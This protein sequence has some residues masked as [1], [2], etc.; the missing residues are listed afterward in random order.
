[1]FNFFLIVFVLFSSNLHANPFAARYAINQFIKPNIAHTKP[2]YFG[3]KQQKYKLRTL[4]SQYHI[5]NLG[6]KYRNSKHPITKVR[7]T[8]DGFPVFKAKYSYRLPGNLLT[9]NDNTQF[10]S[11]TRSLKTAIRR[12]PN[13]KKGYTK[14]Q[15]A[16]IE[17]E[18][19]EIDGLS[20]H[21]SHKQSV[22][23]ELVDRKIHS[24][25]AHTGGRALWGEGNR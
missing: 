2:R 19:A 9:A 23:L 1:L 6:W 16:Q 25:T 14:K 15:L 8:K 5:I 21:H 20:W 22:G 24:K 10:R 7:Y 3:L 18:S 17:K 12:N 11:A 4:P 13:L